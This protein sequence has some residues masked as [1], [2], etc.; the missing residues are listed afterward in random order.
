MMAANKYALHQGFSMKRRLVVLTA[1]ALATTCISGPAQAGW[2]S[3]DDKKTEKTAQ[4]PKA[5]PVVSLDNDLAQAKQL[6]NSGDL[7]GAT[8]VLAQMLLAYPDD[9]RV[10][11][12]YGKVLAQRGRSQDAV[13][14]L[15]RA[16]EILPNDWMIYS[17]LGVAYDQLNDTASARVA[18]ERALQLKPGEPAIL[19]NYGLSRM[20]A[21]DLDGAQR[22]FAQAQATPNANPRI[23][24]NVALLTSIRG[25]APVAPA[26]VA[27]AS[28]RPAAPVVMAKPLPSNVVMQKVPVDP[29]AGPV[30]AAAKPD[31][32]APA[33]H[34]PRPLVADAS[35]NKVAAPAKKKDS[36]PSLR[37]TADASTD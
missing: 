13:N 1:L 11:G 31:N 15:R 23:A 30:V 24:G 7:D 5:M 9:G 19:N 22:L 33:T 17:A 21:K 35:K 10:V 25:P 34:A 28:N 2:F 12:E 3:S 27:V 8:K 14:F 29:K 4:D 36:T 20:L 26:A 37:M 16:A 6:R 32:R 18:Y